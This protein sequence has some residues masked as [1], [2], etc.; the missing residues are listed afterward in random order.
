[1]LDFRFH[2]SL[3]RSIF[4]LFL[5]LLPKRLLWRKFNLPDP[6]APKLKWPVLKNA[7]Q[8]LQQLKLLG[9]YELKLLTMIQP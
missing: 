9:W 2:R 3:P 6:L 4:H 8:R 5:Y 1:V 7:M